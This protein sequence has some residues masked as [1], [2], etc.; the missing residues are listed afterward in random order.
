MINNAIILN[1]AVKNA[2]LPGT[3]FLAM[4]YPLNDETD[5]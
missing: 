2:A 5:L 4:Y 1:F 3:L